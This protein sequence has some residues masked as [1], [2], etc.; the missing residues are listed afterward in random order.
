MLNWQELIRGFPFEESAFP[1]FVGNS[2][3]CRFVSE[4]ASVA[5]LFFFLFPVALLHT[6]AAF[7]NKYRWCHTHAHVERE[8]KKY[9]GTRTFRFSAFSLPK[10]AFLSR[11]INLGLKKL[12]AGSIPAAATVFLMEVKNENNRVSRFRRTLTIPG[13][14]N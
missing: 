14:R 10:A 2:R 8:K 11:E 3:Q 5:Q 13:G 9:V 7:K 6:G 12:H 1:F 4:S